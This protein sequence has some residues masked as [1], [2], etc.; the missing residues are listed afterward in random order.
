MRNY[1]YDH[2][3]GPNSRTRAYY[4][5]LALDKTLADHTEGR[6]NHEKLLWCLLSLEIW[7]RECGVA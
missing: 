6:Q 7:H 1:L 2:L 5:R 3:T 4:H